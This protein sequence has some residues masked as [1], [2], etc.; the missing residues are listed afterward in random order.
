MTTGDRR[1]RPSVG[2]VLSPGGEILGRERTA[3]S[4]GNAGLPVSVK[5]VRAAAKAMRGAEPAVVEVGGGLFGQK[6]Q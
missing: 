3:G 6:V 4:R 5:L 2:Q 1:Q